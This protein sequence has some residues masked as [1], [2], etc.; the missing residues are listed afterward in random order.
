MWLQS[1][2]SLLCPSFV[3][4]VVA[5][6]VVFFVLVALVALGFL[7]ALVVVVVVVRVVVVAAVFVPLSVA[8]PALSNFCSLAPCTATGIIDR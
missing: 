3:F 6:V 7:V 2:V 4:V 5:V 1:V 8:R